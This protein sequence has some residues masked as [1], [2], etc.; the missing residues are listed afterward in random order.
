MHFPYLP[1]AF[2]YCG[3]VF[4]RVSEIHLDLGKLGTPEVENVQ[5]LGVSLQDCLVSGLLNCFDLVWFGL[6]CFR[7][8][9]FGLVLLVL[10]WIGLVW[11]GLNCFDLV[12]IGLI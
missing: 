12:W 1:Q 10:V 6:A 4:L 7:L 3:T 2:L 8:A 11:F 5:T 9:W